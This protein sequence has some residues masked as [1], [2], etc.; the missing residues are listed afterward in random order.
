MAALRTDVE[1]FRPVPLTGAMQWMESATE[2]Q[3]IAGHGN[4]VQAVPSKSRWVEDSGSREIMQLASQHSVGRN[5]CGELHRSQCHRNA[6]LASEAFEVG[7]IL[8]KTLLQ[9]MCARHYTTRNK[10]HPNGS[11]MVRCSE[12]CFSAI[13]VV[14]HATY[15]L[16]KRLLWTSL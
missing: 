8:L 1:N 3:S 11:D 14:C 2:N 10:I 12:P 7:L 15:A 4:K 5:Q 9:Y 13:C 6:I 16:R